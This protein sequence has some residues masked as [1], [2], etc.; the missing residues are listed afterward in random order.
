MLSEF[1]LRKE[2]F[3]CVL[4]LLGLKE[5]KN[6]MRLAHDSLKSSTFVDELAVLPFL[7]Q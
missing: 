6:T 7:D 4:K 5:G 3:S 2:H 1:F